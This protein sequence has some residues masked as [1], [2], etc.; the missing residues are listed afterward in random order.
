MRTLSEAQQIA[1]L[2][3][4]AEWLYLKPDENLGERTK[5]PQIP[6]R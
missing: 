2:L 4:P 1:R 5:T 6:D 3:P